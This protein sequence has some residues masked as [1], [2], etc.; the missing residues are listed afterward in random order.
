MARRLTA[1]P[2][3]SDAKNFRAREAFDKSLEDIL[4][5]VGSTVVDVGSIAAGA[6]G[7]VTVTVTGARA[8]M[9]MTV[10]VGLPSTIS[11]GLVPWANVTADDTVT[12]YLYNRTGSAIDPAGDTY[13]VRVM[14]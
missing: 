5:L 1:P 13:Y 4:K 12:V 3:V 9:G 2:G 6:I 10:Q 14:P 11:T 7:T 8:D